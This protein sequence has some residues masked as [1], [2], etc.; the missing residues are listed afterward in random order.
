MP[1]DSSHLMGQAVG[2]RIRAARLAKK[3]TQNQLA[4]PDFSV[5]YIS[6]IERGQIQPSLRALEILAQRLEVSTS[7]L[8]PV[9]NVTT[10]EHSNT[11]ANT[12]QQREEKELL[13]LEA[14]IA[15]YEGHAEQA[16][17]QINAYIHR[18]INPHADSSSYY[19]LGQAYFE[20]GQLQECERVLA[21]AA[22]LACDAS[23]PLYLHIANL[24]NAVYTAMHH[25]AQASKL[26]NELLTSLDKE[27]IA[28]NDIFFL[29]RLYTNIGE[30]YRQRGNQE[31]SIEYL[32]LALVTIQG[33][34]S[35]QQLKSMYWTLSQQYKEAAQ[36]W[37]SLLY[38]Y[39]WL[40]ANYRQRLPLLRSEIQH[41]LGRA[42]LQNQSEDVYSHLLTLYQQATEEED[43]LSRASACVHLSQWF[44]AHNDFDAAR[45][46]AHEAWDIIGQ[47]EETAISAEVHFI[48][49]EIAYWEQA[50]PSGDEFFQSALLIFE[51]LGKEEEL[52]EHLAIYA[53]QLE[54]KGRIHEAI[55][56][57][58]RAY[59]HHQKTG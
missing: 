41:N 25:P 1:L 42:L 19:I 56:Y 57:W 47:F 44:I 49:G 38:G 2:A 11:N 36:D 20:T 48:Q 39:R 12:T 53:R 7:E 40:Q 9:R 6:A 37:P 28:A 8:L 22:R 17:E 16:I 27:T 15:I 26:Q 51:R 52:S 58:K 23:E 50:D 4:Q 30:L 18:K 55:V 59:E 31:K 13:L 29:T 33:R 46:Y 34:T 21:E 24:Q 35:Y 32:R 10:V 5:S 14:Q 3:Y 54:A 43:Q 45:P